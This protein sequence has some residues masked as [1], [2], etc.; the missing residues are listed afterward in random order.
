MKNSERTPL[1]RSVAD[2]LYVLITSGKWHHQLPGYRKL[3]TIFDVSPRTIFDAL[4]LLEQEK[5]I[6]PAEKGKPRLINPHRENPNT[7]LTSCKNLLVLSGLPVQM[8]NYHTRTVI[9]LTT[10]Y[11]TPKG[12]DISYYHDKEFSRDKPGQQLEKL[13]LN[14]AKHR[15]L[16]VNPPLNIVDWCVS[17]SLEIICLGG[18]TGHHKP[19]CIGVSRIQMVSHAVEFLAKSGHKRICTLLHILDDE[20]YIMSRNILQKVYANSGIQFHERFHM[21][22]HAE[23]TPESLWEVIAR[24]FKVSPPTA[25]IATENQQVASIYSY[26]LAHNIAIPEQLSL[27]VTQEG[28]QLTWFRPTPSHYRYPVQQ[29]VQKITRWIENYPSK[30]VAKHLLQPEFIKGDSIKT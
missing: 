6:L 3:C 10:R 14:H 22:N 7:N 29:Y 4:E 25:L 24:L 8:L 30:A 5:V 1:C 15:W 23:M 26:C 19:P 9:D 13:R 20:A 18:N 27:V 11:L 21:Q 17:N 2:S 16:L 28:R 12:W